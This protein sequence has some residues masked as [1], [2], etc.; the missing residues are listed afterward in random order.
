MDL[1]LASLLTVKKVTSLAVLVWSALLMQ[2]GV[3]E[4]DGRLGR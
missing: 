4:A 1:F 3:K 2:R